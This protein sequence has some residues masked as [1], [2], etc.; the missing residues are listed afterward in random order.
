MFHYEIDSARLVQAISK[1]PFGPKSFFEMACK[2]RP[3][4]ILTN[5]WFAP[6]K[7]CPSPEAAPGLKKFFVFMAYSNWRYRTGG[8]CFGCRCPIGRLAEKMSKPIG[9]VN[10]NNTVDFGLKHPAFYEILA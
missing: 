5:R 10:A 6:A 1:K 4:T 8:N 9:N 2:Q 7:G 3:K